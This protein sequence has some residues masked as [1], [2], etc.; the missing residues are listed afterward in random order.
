[1]EAYGPTRVGV[2]AGQLRALG[3]VHGLQGHARHRLEAR[4]PPRRTLELLLPG[5]SVGHACQI[6]S[7]SNYFP[8][9]YWKSPAARRRSASRSKRRR[10]VD[11]ARP[12]SV[13]TCSFMASVAAAARRRPGRGQ[14][15]QRAP[16]VVGVRPAGD[17]AVRL[18][19]V[20]RVG[21]AGGVD[22]QALADLAQGQRALARERQQHEHLVAGE[23]EPERAKDGVGAGEEDLLQ[24]HD[25]GHDR[26]AR[27]LVRPAV[28]TP[29]ALRLGD[30][31]EAQPSWFGHG[32]T[33]DRARRGSATV[34][35]TSA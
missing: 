8:P 14:A 28:R 29:L 33:L 2:L 31:I 3:P 16:P 15:G 19:A 7:T 11:G 30:R 6:T 32:R 5:L 25:G 4:R 23:R 24:P 13:K 35:T 10:T 34:P 18:Q 17:E 1:M 9:P 26:H 20:D 21:H 12:M 27:R 22:L